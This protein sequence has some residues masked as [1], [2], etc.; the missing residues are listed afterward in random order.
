MLIS[1]ICAAKVAAGTAKNTINSGNY[2]T[3]N[4][5]K[6]FK[7]KLH[8]FDEI[9]RILRKLPED[10]KYIGH[11]PD[12]WRKIFS[13]SEIKSKT[14]EIQKIL[15][16]FSQEV[17]ETDGHPV[18]TEK[19]MEKIGKAL[20]KILGQKAEVGFAGIGMFGPVFRIKTET[21]DLALKYFHKLKFFDLWRGTIHEAY[22]KHGQTMELQNAVAINHAIKPSKRAKFYCGKATIVGQDGGFMLSEFVP[23]SGELR[24]LPP[25]HPKEEFI[26]S[27]FNFGDINTEGNLINGKITD[28][29]NIVREFENKS[30]ENFAK[31]IFPLIVK[32]ETEKIKKLIAL[33]KGNS[34]F[35]KVKRLCRQK[36][37]VIFSDPSIRSLLEHKE[38]GMM[39]LYASLGVL[40]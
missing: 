25:Y 30:Q 19:V 29:G 2:N 31:E 21:E 28:F 13:P 1:P 32:G 26:Y 9:T 20:E 3:I 7:N 12:T 22:K 34:D 18:L 23:S 36:F 5:L 24:V 11:L 8:S 37:D 4:L 16:G 35:E 39:N 17:S 40:G 38:P 33:H 27:K 15:S 10:E 6:Y 14:L